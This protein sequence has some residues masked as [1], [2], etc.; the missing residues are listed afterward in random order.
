MRRAAVPIPEEVDG[1]GAPVSARI[2]IY[3]LDRTIT[4]TAT[5]TRFLLFAIR[6]RTPWRAVFI[7]VALAAGMANALGLIDRRALKQAMHGLALGRLTQDEAARLAEA[8]AARFA[9]RHVRADALARI[10]AD[11]AAGY[12]I[13][14][15]T[16]AYGFY[17]RALAERAGVD[18]L[19]ATRAVAV[20]NH[21]VPLIDGDNLYGAAKLAAIERWLRDANID[22]GTAHIR[23]YSDHASDAP[24]LAWADEALRGVPRRQAPHHRGR[25]RMD[26]PRLALVDE[27]A[28]RGQIGHRVHVDRRQPERALHR[29]RGDPR[30]PA[31]PRDRVGQRQSTRQVA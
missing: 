14:V 31:Q 10:A 2:A 30:R 25:S 12:R 17:A 8:F 27:T 1:T 16:A 13:V 11:R 28:H 22:R 29:R 4:R 21:L 7:P 3:D 19:I 9:P 18:A 15:A 26:D 23:F 6:R 5:W 24:T 20:G